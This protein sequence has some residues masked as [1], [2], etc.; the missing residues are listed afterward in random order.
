MENLTILDKKKVMKDY[1]L[2]E[3]LYQSYLKEGLK[4]YPENQLKKIKRGLYYINKD[5]IPKIFQRKRIPN[6]RNNEWVKEYV[7]TPDVKFD[8][9]G[10]I[11]PQS[12]TEKECKQ[13]IEFLF[14]EIVKN[15]YPD[16]IKLFYFIRKNKKQKKEIST[17]YHI[18]FLIQTDL[19]TNFISVARNTIKKYLGGNPFIQHY[20][21]KWEYEGKAHCVKDVTENSLLG[22]MT[23]KK[24]KK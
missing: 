5:I 18:H 21:Q 23:H 4:T 22:Y 9:I 3:R 19:K 17:Q 6:Q 8:Y 13:V 12:M 14:K 20:K 7:L 15:T 2:Y 10:C 24:R 1:G 11:R 16:E